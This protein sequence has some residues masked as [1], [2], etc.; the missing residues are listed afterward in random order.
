MQMSR[1][2]DFPLFIYNVSA[3]TV[4]IWNCWNVFI[5]LILLGSNRHTVVVFLK[6]SSVPPHRLTTLYLCCICVVLAFYRHYI[7]IQ[8][9]YQHCIFVISELNCV[10][11]VSAGICF[12]SA[13]IDVVSMMH[14]WAFS[15][16]SMLYTYIQHRLQ[17]HNDRSE[18]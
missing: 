14:R 2:G 16:I 15:I 1:A 4:S 18:F 13:D 11:L 7:G 9:V 6:C 10:G 5:G 17:L 3:S 12:V 8:E